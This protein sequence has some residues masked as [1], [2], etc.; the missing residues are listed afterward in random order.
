VLRVVG[1]VVMVLDDECVDE[2]VDVDLMLEVE[3]DGAVVEPPELEPPV[4][5]PFA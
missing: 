4:R 1:V 3:V 2:D 5:V